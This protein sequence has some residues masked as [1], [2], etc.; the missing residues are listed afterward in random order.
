M[1]KNLIQHLINKEI[2]TVADLELVNGYCKTFNTTFFS[3]LLSQANIFE[4]KMLQVLAEYFDFRFE[5]IDEKLVDPNIKNILPQE[6]ILIYS[7]LP[8]FKVGN[9]L[10][11]AVTNPFQP[12]IFDFLSHKLNM[13]LDYVLTNQFCFDKV[14]SYLFKLNF[15]LSKVENAHFPYPELINQ[16]HSVVELV[17]KILYQAIAMHASDIHIE[18]E[19][20]ELKIRFRLDGILKDI[21]GLPFYFSQ[22]VISRFKVLAN[23]DVT[24]VRRPQDGRLLFD[25]KGRKIDFRLSTIKTI[26]GEKM[27]L[28]VL[29]QTDSFSQLSDLGFSKKQLQ[30]LDPLIHAASGII[31]VCGPTGSGK[32]STLYS[33]LQIL[34][35][36]D[37]NIITIEDPVEYKFKGLNQIAIDS[38]LDLTFAKGLKSVLRQ[39]PDVIM[40]GE[41]RDYETGSVS[42][43]AALT[44]HLVLTTLHTRSAAGTISRLLDMGHKPFMLN[45][46]ILSIISQRLVRKICPNC[47]KEQTYFSKLS[48]REALLYNQI[49]QNFKD[50]NVFYGTGCKEC[51]YTG[52]KGRTGIFEIL[53]LNE[54]IQ[55]HILAQ[56]SVLTIHQAAI[57]SGM[58]S[59][60]D[61]VIEKI[62][63]GITSLS[64]AARVLDL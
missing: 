19:Q 33:M 63:R 44:G 50:H 22:S 31:I 9:R 34:N 1:D 59:I 2:F 37:K 51:F 15:G 27:V 29:D 32:T 17:D 6:F 48:S 46:T 26:S 3:A 55:E 43:Q 4:D 58:D 36:P 5:R 18:P 61:D 47:K 23:M 20:N 35:Q 12:V 53:I 11:V 16:D 30:I 56:K 38:K 64:E 13:T 7:I 54:S 21:M 57:Q 45:S 24:E 52:Y 39:D 41:V 49:K 40:V 14:F 28:R 10:I 60:K 25:F 62:C 42:I 8:L